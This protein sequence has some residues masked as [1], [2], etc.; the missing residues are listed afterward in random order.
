M[1]N[2][3]MNNKDHQDCY[4]QQGQLEVAFL[5]LRSTAGNSNCTF[6]ASQYCKLA[7]QYR[8]FRDCKLC[9]V[10]NFGVPCSVELDETEPPENSPSSTLYLKWYTFRILKAFEMFPSQRSRNQTPTDN[11]RFQYCQDRWLKRYNIGCDDEKM[12]M[13][14]VMKMMRMMMMMIINTSMNMMIM[15][16]MI[17]YHAAVCSLQ[18]AVCT[19]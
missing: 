14:M 10:W 16:M 8:T 5:E 15:M 6:T 19:S 4:K 2:T 11:S 18:F 9:H 17:N 1:I 3:E 13:T 7:S 12:I